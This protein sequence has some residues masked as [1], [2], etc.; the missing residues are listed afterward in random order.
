MLSDPTRLGVT[1]SAAEAFYTGATRLQFSWFDRVNRLDLTGGASGTSYG[2][3]IYGDDLDLRYSAAYRRRL[4]PRL[5][6]DVTGAGWQFR[7]ADYS[8]YDMSQHRAAVRLGW[9]AGPRWVFTAGLNHSWTSYPGRSVDFDSTLVESQQLMDLG[10]GA[11]LNLG[12]STI[13]AEGLWRTN[14]ANTELAR[15]DGPVLS[16][17]LRTALPGRFG[18][19]SYA[20]FGRRTYDRVTYVVGTDKATMFEQTVD[21]VDETWQLGLNLTRFLTPRFQLFAD[22]TWLNQDSSEEAFGFDQ[23]RFS[24]GFSVN[25]I[26]PA[27]GRASPSIDMATAAP[28][29]PRVTESGTRFRFR[30]PEASQISL[31]GGFNA[32][33]AGTHTLSGPDANGI[34]ETVVPI[35]PGIY[36]YAFIVDGEWKAPPDAPRYED[37]GFGGEN[38]VLEITGNPLYQ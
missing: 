8:I 19:S 12:A 31:V 38:G 2:T 27:R 7:R 20:L 13:T 37:D 25:L 21:R 15:Y 35:Q 5:M 17:R 23:T 18:M 29:V 34:W 28:L 10:I 9:S 32:W 11:S 24:L 36:R 6:V 26:E 3:H 14:R 1:Q 4:A 22:L 33:T 16:L 30:A